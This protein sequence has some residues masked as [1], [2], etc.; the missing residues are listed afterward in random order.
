MKKTP[1]SPF[2]SVLSDHILENN[3]A[4]CHNQSH[5]SK[6]SAASLASILNSP[7]A[8]GEYPQG[9]GVFLQ[10]EDWQA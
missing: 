8:K 6:G 3:L 7:P 9:E 4:L 5:L 1:T 2:L 10:T